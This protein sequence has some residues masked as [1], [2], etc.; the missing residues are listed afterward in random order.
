MKAETKQCQNCNNSFIIEEEDF[1]FYEKIK[2]PSPTWC[3]DCRAMR[4]LIWRN[5]RSLYN[6]TCA[7]SGRSIISMFAPGTKLLVYERDIWWSDKWDPTDYGKDYDFSKPFFEQYKDLL[8]K[9]PLASV[10]NTNIVNSDYCNHVVDCRNCYLV[11]ASLV[12][13]NVSYSQGVLDTR[14]SFD[15]YT[16]A[17]SEQSYDDS[18][19]AGL[20]KTHFSFNTDDSINSWFLTSCMNLQDCL[21]CVNLRHKTHCIFNKQYTKE[22]YDKEI[23]AYDFGS[24]KELEKFKKKYDIFLKAQPWRFANIL[25]SI[26]V[27]GDNVMNSK[28]SKMIFDVYG[29]VEDSKY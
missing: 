29:N 12:N 20:Y 6:N 28:N 10:G 2:V 18:V 9:V 26:S 17:K 7:F 15:L 14:D 4:R 23:S 22:E 25:K 3:P 8:S 24:Y 27:T 19:S 16:V 1:N 13:E 5:E 11:Y 21:G